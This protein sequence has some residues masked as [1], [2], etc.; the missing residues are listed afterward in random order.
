MFFIY[1]YCHFIFSHFLGQFNHLHFWLGYNLIDYMSKLKF[2]NF[3]EY[4]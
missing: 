2:S 4:M 3:V 1:R